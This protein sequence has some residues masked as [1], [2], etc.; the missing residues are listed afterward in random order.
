M[1]ANFRYF[2]SG[3]WPDFN[4]PST[5]KHMKICVSGMQFCWVWLIHTFPLTHSRACLSLNSF[6][7]IHILWQSIQKKFV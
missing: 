6:M 5:V 2:L 7:I 3:P 1:E 4:Q